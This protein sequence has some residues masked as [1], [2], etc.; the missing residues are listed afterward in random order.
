MRQAS[1]EI[2][3]LKDQLERK[4]LYLRDEIRLEHHGEVVGNSEAI[5]RVLEPIEQV[6]ATDSSVLLL[7]ENWKRQG[8]AR[9]QHS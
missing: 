4:N 1:A 9:P 2:R 6:G 8:T 5:R 7:G 3:N